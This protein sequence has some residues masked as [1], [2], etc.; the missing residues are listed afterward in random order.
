[1]TQ[2]EH[3]YTFYEEI[4]RGGMGIV[5]RAVHND[6]KEEVAIKVLH[7]ELVHDSKQVERFER[8]ARS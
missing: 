4:G 2:K 8:E 6:T 3:T 7:K 5:Y 1:M